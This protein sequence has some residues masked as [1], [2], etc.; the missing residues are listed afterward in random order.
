MKHIGYVKLINNITLSI[1]VYMI[2]NRTKEQFEFVTLITVV[3]IHVISIERWGSKLIL[4]VISYINLIRSKVIDGS[5]LIE[6][7]QTILD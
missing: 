7:Q 4:Y 2:S 3:N 6:G 5:Y 1:I